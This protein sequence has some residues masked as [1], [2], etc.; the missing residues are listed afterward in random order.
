MITLNDLLTIV[1][2][3]QLRVIISITPRLKARLTVNTRN[4]PELDDLIRLYGEYPVF[5]AEPAAEM[6]CMEIELTGPHREDLAL[7][8]LPKDGDAK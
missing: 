4:T 5:S 7:T 1:N 6:R 2:A 3:R 8:A